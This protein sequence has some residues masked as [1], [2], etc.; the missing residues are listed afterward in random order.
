M[1]VN[2]FAALIATSLQREDRDSL[3]ETV[4]RM[5]ACPVVGVICVSQISFGA[6]AA[7]GILVD[8]AARLIGLNAEDGFIL[9]RILWSTRH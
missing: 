1:I 6:A 9:V 2:C 8:D 4:Q 3:S 5:E 7:A